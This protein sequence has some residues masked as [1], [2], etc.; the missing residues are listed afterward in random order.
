MFS[1]NMMKTQIKKH[2]TLNFKITFKKR[3]LSEFKIR[4]PIK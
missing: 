4:K 3:K 2:T 1:K